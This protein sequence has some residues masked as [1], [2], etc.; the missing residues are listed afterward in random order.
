MPII[1]QM[2]WQKY[3]N[4]VYITHHKNL[5]VI[6]V[7]PKHNKLNKEYGTTIMLEKQQLD[8]LKNWNIA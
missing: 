8:G 4:L 3:L 7:Y 5:S 2:E 1:T 6:L